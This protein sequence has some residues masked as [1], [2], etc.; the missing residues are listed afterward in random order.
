VIRSILLANTSG[1]TKVSNACSTGGHCAVSA[2]PA[3]MRPM[4]QGSS[5]R[6]FRALLTTN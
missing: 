3:A 2:S 5:R 6:W 1:S 4:F